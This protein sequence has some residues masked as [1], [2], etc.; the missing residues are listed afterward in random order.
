MY[1]VKLEGDYY[2]VYVD[3][4]MIVCNCT[5]NDAVKI[6]QDIQEKEQQSNK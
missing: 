3:G 6:V 1:E 5:L 4:R 2:T